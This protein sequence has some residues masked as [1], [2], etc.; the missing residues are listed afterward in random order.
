MLLMCSVAQDRDKQN[1]ANVFSGSGYG[2]AECW[3]CVQW[4]R[5]GTSRM[6][7]MC[8]VAQERDKQNVGDVFSGSGCA[9]LT[10]CLK[11]QRIRIPSVV[12]VDS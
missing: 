3:Q 6:L 12:T 11:A 5:T 8:S 10:S 7:A 1:V 9:R 4:L 2:Q